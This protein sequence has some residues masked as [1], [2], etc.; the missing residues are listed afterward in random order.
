MILRAASRCSRLPP[1]YSSRYSRKT[2][3][4]DVSSSSARILARFN[5]PS[6]TVIVRFAAV[7]PIYTGSVLHENRPGQRDVGRAQER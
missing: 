5:G 6:S 3:L 1:A 7:P 2:A 4:T